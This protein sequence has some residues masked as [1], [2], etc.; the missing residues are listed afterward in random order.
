VTIE[1]DQSGKIEQ[2]NQATILALSNGQRFSVIISAKTK[3]RLQQDFRYRGKPRLFVLRTFA[4]CL[5]LL[6]RHAQINNTQVIT[7]DEEYSGNDIVLKKMI[8]EMWDRT[9]NICERPSLLFKRI[10]KHSPAHSLAYLTAT[11][12]QEVNLV[13]TYREIYLLAI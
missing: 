6:L 1:I 11:G 9:P 3:R 2:T 7:I 12:K 4:A 5:T 10:G 13:L 8:S